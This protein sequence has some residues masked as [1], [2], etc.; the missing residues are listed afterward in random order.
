MNDD[1]DRNTEQKITL[2]QLDAILSPVSPVTYWQ[3]GMPVQRRDI[4]DDC[5]VVSVGLDNQ[6]INGRLKSCIAVYVGG[7]IRK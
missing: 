6:V 2:T 7:R 4:F 1:T 5:E 3:D